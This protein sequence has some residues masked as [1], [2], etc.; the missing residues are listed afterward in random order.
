MRV[1]IAI[2]IGEKVKKSLDG[3]LK[4]LQDSVDI[5]KGDVKWVRPDNMHLTL[6]FLGEIKDDKIAEVCNI[7]EN[8][9]GRHKSFELNVESLGYFGGKT[10]RVLWVGTGAGSDNLRQ[11][12][13]E[14]EQELALA[15]WPEE[16][17]E[18][19]GHLTL[20]RINNPA[21]G[22]K[23]ARISEDYKD[24]KVGVV[25]A[26]SVSVYQSQLMPAGP[27]YTVLGNYKLS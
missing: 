7:V 20:C 8:V 21:A 17:R 3:L 15:G 10:A 9:A 5:R 25:S 2:D 23:L 24:F 12:A 18:F 27:I 4:Q 19:S 1:F 11:L 14:L 22:A 26:D 16:T 6:K 13:E